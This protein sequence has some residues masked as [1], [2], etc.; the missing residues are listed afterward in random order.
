MADAGALLDR[1]AAPEQG[2]ALPG[3]R[4]GRARRPLVGLVAVAAALPVILGAGLVPAT[5]AAAASAAAASAVASPTASAASSSSPTASPT[6]ATTPPAAAALVAAPALRQGGCDAGTTL[7]V[8]AHQDDDLL[9]QSTALLADLRAGRCVTTVYVTAGDAGEGAEYV[10]ARETG[11]RS[12]YAQILGAADAWDASTVDLHG[13]AVGLARLTGDARVQMLSLHLPDGGWQGE[14]FESTGRQTLEKLW[15]G[16]IPTVS[17]VDGLTS[18]TLAQLRAQ[19]LAITTEVQPTNVNTLDHHGTVG[20]GDHPDHHVVAY[21]ADEAQAAAGTGHG[22]AGWMGYPIMLRPSNLTDEQAVDKASAFFRYAAH[23]PGTCASAETC[24]SRPE[25][26]W[27]TREYAVGTPTTTPPVTTPVDPEP[28]PA[29][30]DLTPGAVASAAWENAADGQTAAAAIDGVVDGYP[31]AS[32]AEWV[33]PWGGVGVTF[34]LTWPTAVTTDTVVLHDRVNL[35]DQVTGG[36]LTFSD[37][38]TVAVPSLENAGGATTVS[39][40]ARAT[41]SLRLTVTSVSA[42]T[43]NVGLAEIGA[44]STTE[45]AAP[46][47]TP[48]PTPLST[49]DVTAGATATASSESSADGQAAAKAIDGV[50]DGY[51]GVHTAEWATRGGREGSWLQLDW[52]AARTVDQV[53]LHDRPN[54]SDQ[55]TGATLSFSDGST[56]SVPSL[57]DGGGASVV[58]FPARSTSSVRVT[59]TS[60]SAT[61]GNVGLAEL[62]VRS[63]VAAPAAPGTPAVP[64]GTDVTAGAVA[65]AAWENAADGQT[66]AAAID[67]VVGGYPA[68]TSAE[69]VAPWGGVGVTYT[70]TWASPVTTD[71]VVLHDRVNLADQV[72]GGTLTFSDGSTVA[73]PALENAGGATT[74][75]FPARATTSVRFTVTSVSASTRDVGLA[76]L[77]VLRQG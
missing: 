51:P 44:Y 47:P 54:L 10:R 35:S 53:V 45:P 14:G 66:A 15:T 37:G 25:G 24:A 21:L 34:T 46:T 26:R 67:G 73:V 7:N 29:L 18:Y 16:T 61:T 72:T 39:F 55:V 74:V 28:T 50:V 42:S 33:A 2:A 12:A 71:A 9:F 60:V 41:T 17:S 38:S 11:A 48:T 4:P 76:E 77:R 1:D 65:T 20:D 5:S 49:Y 52:A 8:V 75:T 27:L 63:A 58:S 23:D 31:G 68:A 30:Y 22:F 59:I 69:W 19:L 56:V 70:L 40:P 43:R 32:T 62:V 13:H 6:S 3:R 36:T 57:A 64:T